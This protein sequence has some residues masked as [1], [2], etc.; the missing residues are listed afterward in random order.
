MGLWPILRTFGHWLSSEGLYNV[1]THIPVD[2]LNLCGALFVLALTVPVWR[3][4]GLAAAAFILVNMLPPIAAGGALSAGRLSAVMF[5]VFLWLAS[6]VPARQRP[7]W[8]AAFAVGQGLCATLFYTW[9]E[10]F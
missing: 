4:L 3:R 6:A 7:H 8:V 9:R 1:T 10:L 2:V 5:P